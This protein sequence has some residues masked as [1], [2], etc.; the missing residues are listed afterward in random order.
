MK[1]RPTVFPDESGRSSALFW[2]GDVEQRLGAFLD[3]E[4]KEDELNRVNGQGEKM[5]LEDV[6]IR[7]PDQDRLERSSFARRLAESILS[8]RGEE[9]IVIGVYGAW[10]SGKTSILNLTE[11]FLTEAAKGMADEERPFILRFNPWN[12][13]EQA[14]LMSMFFHQLAASLKMREGD[15]RLTELAKRVAGYGDFFEP[16]GTLLFGPVGG[17]IG[18]LVG[19]GVEVAGAGAKRRDEDFA[20]FREEID[21]TL[22]R[23]STRLVIIIDD[24]DRLNATEIK[25]M[26]QLVKL[27]AD[28]P[29][30]IYL[31]AFD[32]KVVRKALEESG[33]SGQAYLEKIVQVAFQMP[34]PETELLFRIFFEQLDGVLGQV[35]ETRW[36][37]RRWV[38]L[39]HAGLKEFFSNVRD[40]KRFI[41]A[42]RLNYG[43]VAG[44][45][46]PIDFIGVEALRVFVPEAYVAMAQNKEFF[47]GTRRLLGRQQPVSQGLD[48][49][50]S[51]VHESQR[52][53]VRAICGQLFPQIGVQY[54]PGTYQEWRRQLRICVPDMFERYFLL[55]I[56]AGEISEVELETLLELTGHPGQLA[57]A[58]RELIEQGR[59]RRFLE[60]MEDYADEVPEDHIEPLCLALLNIGDELPVEK[61]GF[62]DFGADVQ[63]VRVLYQLLKRLPGS[64]DVCDLLVRVFPQSTSVFTPVNVVSHLTYLSEKEEPSD[65]VLNASQLQPLQ[66][67]CVEKVQIAR[68]QSSLQKVPRLNL[69]LLHW[70]EWGEPTDV[71][72][73]VADLI[74]VPEGLAD[75]LAGFLYQIRSGI[76][77]EHYVTLEWTIDL[78]N[79]SRYVEIEVLTERLASLRNQ[80]LASLSERQRLA[81]DTFSKRTNEARES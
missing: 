71:R 21:K 4:S 55:G 63:L 64:Q 9:S 60:R 31:L 68:N 78:D 16:A 10:G 27:N 50:L 48:N 6:P 2:D 15:E 8:W 25:Q 34:P 79:V 12:F 45:V 44:E 14:Q 80:D 61:R 13:A 58:L 76:A 36:D 38:N 24:L 69:L 18:R 74:A 29:N 39:F 81:I 41:N 37:E 26:F 49:L 35:P 47:V 53:T 42:L 62:L 54:G 56:P 52:E 66:E 51:R 57:S 32:P 30:T 73:Y 40:I 33:F 3:V 22:R 67:L 70:N 20:T 28:F 72:A 19:K 17:L 43:L 77:G 11:Y 75:F 65:L 5:Y 59:V 23:M 1:K 7:N 46:N